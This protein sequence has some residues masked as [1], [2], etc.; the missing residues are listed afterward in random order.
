MAKN[1]CVIQGHPYSDGKRLCHALAASY[2]RGARSRGA[3]VE[4]VDLGAMDIRMLRN[5]EDFATPAAG[6]IRAAQDA[7]VRCDHLV[8][9][10]PLWL[11]S[12]PALVKAFFEQLARNEFALGQNKAGW[13]RKML[14]GRSARVVV[15]MGMPAAAYRL[16]FGA[17]G[18]KSLES[19][20][21]AMAGFK[22]I[23]ETLLGGVG[24]LKKKRADS[25]IA[26]LSA[27]GADDAEPRDSRRRASRTKAV[28]A[29]A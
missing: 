15:T 19:G 18:V 23:K 16:V 9:I 24:E 22:P 11:G 3:K 27:I 25:L 29:V 14:K 28:K 21:L 17:H 2:A 12:M 13:P 6:E 5:P 26:R 8:V 1:I 20:I 7:V 10:Y 4:M